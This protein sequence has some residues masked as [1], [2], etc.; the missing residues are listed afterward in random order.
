MDTV[1]DRTAGRLTS[2]QTDRQV[3]EYKM[4]KI[5]QREGGGREKK[6]LKKS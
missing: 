1:P 4:V 2:R 6:L 5:E 3:V